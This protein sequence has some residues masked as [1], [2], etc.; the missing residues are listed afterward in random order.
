[1]FFK[2]A[3]SDMEKGIQKIQKCPLKNSFT[4]EIGN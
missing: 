2:P 4:A 3:E 1:M